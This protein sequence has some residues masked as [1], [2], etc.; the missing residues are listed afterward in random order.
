MRMGNLLLTL[1][2]VSIKKGKENLFQFA[3]DEIKQSEFMQNH[4]ENP[5][6]TV[7]SLADKLISRKKSRA[8]V[9]P[10]KMIVSLNI[11]TTYFQFQ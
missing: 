7:K 9:I 2:S 11:F 3:I 10:I 8:H 6:N 5:P 1:Q 4:H